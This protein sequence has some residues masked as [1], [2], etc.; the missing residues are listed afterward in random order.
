MAANPLLV[1]VSPAP[2]AS[3]KAIFKLQTYFQSGKRS[4]GGECNVRPG[5]QVGTYWVDFFK[6]QGTGRVPRLGRAGRAWGVALRG[7][8]MAAEAPFSVS[9]QGGSRAGGRC[10]VCR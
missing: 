3:E 5:P 9:G 8:E 10:H 7:L 6:E 4:G 1:R 2:A